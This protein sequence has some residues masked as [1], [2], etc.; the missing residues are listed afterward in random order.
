L[1][2]SQQ[3]H[4]NLNGMVIQ[5]FSSAMITWN[6]PQ[7]LPEQIWNH[8]FPNTLPAQPEMSNDILVSN[9]E[10]FL[11]YFEQIVGIISIKTLRT[12]WKKKLFFLYVYNLQLHL[13]HFR[14]KKNLQLHLFCIS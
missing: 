7:L 10:W 4:M 13:L 1:L 3:N 5:A 8:L 9:L 14:D 12:L 2:A 11:K 6:L